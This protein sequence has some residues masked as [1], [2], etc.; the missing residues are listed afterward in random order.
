MQASDAVEDVRACYTRVDE[1][2]AA[3]DAFVNPIARRAAAPQV[4]AAVTRIAELYAQMERYRPALK[5]VHAGYL[6]LFETVKLGLDDADAMNANR[7]A[8]AKGGREGARAKVL[9]AMA[10]YWQAGQNPAAQVVAITKYA[11]AIDEG[12]GNSTRG[13]FTTIFLHNPP[14]DEDVAATLDA[15]FK[16]VNQS[17]SSKIAARSIS[18]PSSA[19][20]VRAARNMPLLMDM[21]GDAGPEDPACGV[22]VGEPLVITGKLL[23]GREFSSA[24]WKGKVILVDFWATW[25]GP[26]VADIGHIKKVYADNHGKGLEVVSVSC[27]RTASALERFLAKNPEMSW[28]QMYDTENPG[29][30]MQEHSCGV[31]EIPAQFLIDRKGIL[32]SRSIGASDKLQLMIT[33]LLA[34][35]PDPKSL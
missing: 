18:F 1:E 13:L 6:E 14:A 30:N 28:P 32:R 19:A 20:R 7:A 5:E 3:E 24:N 34:E 35:A 9:R 29:S 31:Y 10:D 12:A 33:K 27:D 23:D 16:A 26:C 21:W 8:L 25:C 11:A 2:I 22:V 17:S 15:V 4:A